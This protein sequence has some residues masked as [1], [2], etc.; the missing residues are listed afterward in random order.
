M[1]TEANIFEINR[2]LVTEVN[3]RRAPSSISLRGLAPL[4]FPPARDNT[5]LMDKLS[6]EVKNQ[7]EQKKNDTMI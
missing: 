5:W 2:L 3:R 7:V 4:D 6:D 1:Q